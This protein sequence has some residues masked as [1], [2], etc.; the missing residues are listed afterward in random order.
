M[1]SVYVCSHIY[2]LCNDDDDN[3]NYKIVTMR[4]INSTIEHQRSFLWC[5]LKAKEKMNEW[6]IHFFHCARGNY[7][8]C[9]CRLWLIF[10][11]DPF[12]EMLVVILWI[13]RSILWL[14][15]GII[16]HICHYQFDAIASVWC[17]MQHEDN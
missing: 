16:L 15:L 8:H 9:K 12:L 5:H 14:A 3:N 1:H 7:A 11:N 17:N 13:L 10:H 6:M 4:I 2:T